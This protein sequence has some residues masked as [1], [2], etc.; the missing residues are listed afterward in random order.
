M[1]DVDAQN[2]SLR[3]SSGSNAEMTKDNDKEYMR[4]YRAA[5]EPMRQPRRFEQRERSC[6]KS[7]R[8]AR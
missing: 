5:C 1:T 2:F 4:F 7:I 8:S 3:T 6:H